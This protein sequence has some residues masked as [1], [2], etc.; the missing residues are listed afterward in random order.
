M[1]RWWLWGLL[2]EWKPTWSEEKDNECPLMTICKREPKLYAILVVLGV[3]VE[4]A[5]QLGQLRHGHGVC[6]E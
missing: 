4:G 2:T 5:M 6:L 3:G 1:V